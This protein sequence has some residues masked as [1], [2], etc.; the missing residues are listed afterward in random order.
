M[1]TVSLDPDVKDLFDEDF[2][3]SM[4]F[5]IEDTSTSHVLFSIQ[6][7]CEVDSSLVIT[8]SSALSEILHIRVQTDCIHTPIKIKCPTRS[9]I[10]TDVLD[11]GI[12][13]SCVMV[14]S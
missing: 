12:S 3:L 7:S 14:A 2:S 13:L 9:P 10:P 5:W 11:V 1:D 6:D 4:S 8:Y